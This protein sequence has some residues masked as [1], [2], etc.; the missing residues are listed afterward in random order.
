M[1]VRLALFAVAFPLV[2]QQGCPQQALSAMSSL[3]MQ[4]ASTLITALIVV[5]MNQLFPST[6][7]VIP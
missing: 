6:G 5:L 4:A 2:A 1:F 7:T 3:A